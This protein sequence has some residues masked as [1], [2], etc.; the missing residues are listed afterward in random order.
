[1]DL[2][3]FTQ[4]VENMLFE[5]CGCNSIEAEIVLKECLKRIKQGPRYKR[6]AEVH[7]AWVEKWANFVR[8][9]PDKSWSEMQAELIDSQLEN[10]MQVKLSK[11]QVAYIKKRNK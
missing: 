8:N 1:M 4:R 6:D 9:N 11:E 3:K 2:E 10:A 7:K 5:T